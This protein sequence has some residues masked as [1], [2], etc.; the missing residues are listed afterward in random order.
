[1][2]RRWLV[3]CLACV[4][5]TGLLQPASAAPLSLDEC[6]GMRD[7]V[8]V[9]HEDDDLLFMNPDI[10][11]IIGAGGCMRVVYLTAAERGEGVAYM[12]GRARGIRAAYAMLA[13]KPDRWT[14]SIVHYDDKHQ[15]L[16]VLDGNPRISH[17]YLRLGDPWLGGKGWGDLT[18][19][20][21]VES[22]PGAIAFS[23]GRY[24]DRYTRRDL[25]ATIADMIREYRPTTV[26]H[27]DGTI[28]V[29]YTK[30]CWR[31]VGDDHPDHIASARLV[32]AAMAAAPGNYAQVG[33]VDYP[34]Q[35]RPP[36]LNSF[37]IQ[38]KSRVFRMYAE[39]DY[40]YCKNP[41]LC[42]EP[43]GPA[44]AWVGRSYYIEPRTTPPA[45]LPDGHGGFLLFTIGEK[46]SA[47]NVYDSRSKAWTTLGG[48]F[49]GSLTAFTL[50]QDHAGLLA[51]D[52]TGRLWLATRAP[53]GTWG[54]WTA[55]LGARVVDHPALA[56]GTDGVSVIA[57]GNDG[58][59][60]HAELTFKGIDVMPI[61]WKAMPALDDALPHAAAAQDTKGRLA[62]FAA[63]RQGRLWYTVRPAGEQDWLPW[64]LMFRVDTSGGLAAVRNRDGAIE[65][66]ARDK[67][68]SH[69]LRVVEQKHV[70]RSVA[71][72]EPKDLNLAYTGIPTAGLDK[73][74]NVAVAVRHE[75]SLWLLAQGEIHD[76]GKGVASDP[77]SCMASDL[78]HVVGRDDSANQIYRVWTRE[79]EI[80]TARNLATAPP[81]HG[82]ISISME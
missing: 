17:V 41:A 62:V 51:R 74:G 24:Q 82:G 80:W 81:L 22:V 77:A 31:C 38:R 35:E 43:L 75:G 52:G 44:A 46:N 45:L 8:F 70:G 4:L 13:G 2:F 40:K 72:G 53:D 21:R 49:I 3:L 57:M 64:H 63:D 20:S 58:V 59:F 47:A 27:M 73:Q 48:R 25:V 30:L 33:Y 29:P 50:P 61:H 55:F 56:V 67:A 60:Q 23:I 42:Q 1:M 10:S 65:L 5:W 34:T 9:A 15:F 26:R 54:H 66:Y 28:T 78:F 71:W 39:H 12:Q 11:T 16:F 6:H 68:S 37:E 7:L 14:K 36:N 79:R 18:P 19:L 76:L 32:L 69:L